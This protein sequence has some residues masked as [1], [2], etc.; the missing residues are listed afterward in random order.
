MNGKAHPKAPISNPKVVAPFPTYPG[1]KAADGVIQFLINRV[2]RHFIY[3]EP[4][5]GGGAMYLHKKRCSKAYLSDI[6]IRVV[7][8]WEQVEG[9]YNEDR[10][11][12]DKICPYSF[13]NFWRYY[14]QVGAA[15]QNRNR[16]TFVFLDPPYL[17]ETR[18]FQKKIY[19]YEFETPEQHE[20]LLALL[21]QDAPYS[22]DRRHQSPNVMIAGY[23]SELYKDLLE[24]AGWL[25]H[26]FSGQTRRG[27]CVESIWTNY[28]PEQWP[29]HDYT[30][31]GENTRER[32]QFRQKKKR[33][34]RRLS[35]MN[36][37]EREALLRAIKDTYP[38]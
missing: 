34:I 16:G 5:L 4:F 23:P 1:G 22:N 33:W 17:M 18:S 3:M 27:R 20:K 24:D 15:D 6:N 10:P 13:S 37:R 25:R 19:E 28:D 9:V 30:Y 35:E 8:A 12:V 29:L 7:N 38:V 14:I 21:L 2:P 31:V 11:E 26:D 32:D 36:T